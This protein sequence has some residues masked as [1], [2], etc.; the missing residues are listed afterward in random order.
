MRTPCPSAC[1]AALTLAGLLTAGC[2]GKAPVAPVAPPPTPIVIAAPADK[3]KVTAAMTITAGPEANPDRSGRPSPVVVRVYQLRTDAA[4]NAASFSDL[5]EKDD[6]GL[7]AEMISRDEYV[8]AP[9]ESRTLAVALADDTRF[10]GAVAGFRDIYAPNAQW[11]VTVPTPTRGLTI[12]VDR[13]RLVM[14]AVE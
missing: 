10:V 14:S 2:G 9:K 5:L 8:L 4:F 13:T 11:R 12:A 6:A 1:T 7:G 3:P